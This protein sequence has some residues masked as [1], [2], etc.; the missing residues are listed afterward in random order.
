MNSNSKNTEQEI[1]DLWEKAGNALNNQQ[2]LNKENMETL[3]NKTSSEFSTGQK[4]LLKADALFKV[5][6]IFGFL[7]ISAFN[8]ANLFV[9]ATSLI[10][11]IIGTL[12]IKQ[13]RLMIE[14]LNE[15]DDFHG[16]IR[17]QLEK[18]IQ[19][20]RSNI[21]RYPLVLA[22][23]IF[24][25]YILG[26]LIYHGIQY[27]V[28]RP[29]EDL[30]DGIVLLSFLMISFIFAFS[31]YYPFFRMRINYLNSLLKD[32]DQEDKIFR[33]IDSEDARKKKAILLTS[34]LIIA[35]IVILIVLIIAIL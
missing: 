3:L 20:Y 8:L 16:N 2:Q 19:F 28:I 23:S 32:I 18:D 24:L 34:I 15:L 17:D 33:H 26:S 7:I 6:L 9:I 4:K 1:F 22:T 10:C 27:E 29:V 35:G 31:V 25:F 13:E 21:F 11:I 14:G 5:A 12:V 30:E